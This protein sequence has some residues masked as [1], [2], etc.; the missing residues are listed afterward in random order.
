MF[1][2]TQKTWLT[3][4][5][6]IS[7]GLII[8]LDSLTARGTA[9]YI[10]YFIPVALCVFHKK[11][12]YPLW[13]ALLCSLLS[14]LGYVLSPVNALVANSQLPLLNRSFTIITLWAV[15]VLVRTIIIT[16]NQVERN[17]WLRDSAQKLAEIIRGELTTREVSEGILT[18]LAD[19]FHGKVGSLYLKAEKDNVLN[20]I[21]GHAYTP[22]HARRVM[23]LDDSLLGQTAKARKIRLISKLP[24]DYI[25]I[26]SSLGEGTPKNL[27]IVPFVADR[28]LIG[29]LELG[30]FDDPES[31]MEDFLNLISESC[32]IAIRSAEN[33]SRLAELLH[34]SQQQAEELQAQQEELRVVNEELEQQSRA[35]KDSHVRLENQQAELE[36]SNQ[37]L[38]EQAQALESQKDALD[39]KN[40]DL[41]MA[42]AALEQKAHELEKSSSYKS[43]FLANMSHELR[44]PLNSTLIL[45]KL[46]FDNKSGNLTA[47]Q[48]KYADIIYNSGNDLL[49]LINDIL[50]LS[51]VEAGKML[52]TPEVIDL[53]QIVTAME[54]NFSALANQ[55]KLQF[56]V[57]L[58]AGLPKEFISDKLRVEQILKNFLSNAFKFTSKGAVTLEISSFNQSIAFK[59]IDTGPGIPRSQQDVIFEA[60]RQADGTTN[61]KFGGT[62][63]GLSI[64]KELSRL[65]NG[66]ITIESQE[67]KGSIIT[68]ILPE[69]FELLS[70]ERETVEVK[71]PNSHIVAPAKNVPSEKP[72]MK[73][74][75][76]DDRETIQN[77]KRK[78]LIIEDDEPF[79]QILFG[80]AHENNFGALVAPTA[81][82]GL[83]LAKG[84]SPHAVL[85]DIRLPD[86]SGLMVLD[87]LKMDTKTRH[88]PVHIISSEDFTK[89]AMEM[90]AIGYMLKPV[91]HEQLLEA[92][93]NLT[94]IME[95]KIKR[96]LVV[97]DDEVQRNHIVSLIADPL[98]EVDAIATSREALQK[99]SERTYDCMIMDLSLP[100][101]SG[102]DLLSKLSK[103]NSTYSYPP[104]IVYTARDL[105]REEE[106]KLRLY[107]GS[108]IIKGAKSPERLLS[109]VTLF[110]HRV[111]TDMPAERQKMLKDL[112]SREK[113]LQ[114]R[115]LLVVDDDVRNIFALTSALEAFGARVEVARNGAEALE[116]LGN[117]SDVDLVLMDIMMPEMDGYEAMRRIRLEKRWKDLPII[118]LTAKAMK[119]DR[120]KC[121]EAGANDYLSKPLN[122]EKLLSLTRVWLPV[123]RRF[124]L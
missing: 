59:V 29:A 88:I 70:A 11:P 71:I 64:S 38:E 108:I 6:L 101:L 100:D 106:E 53:K 115:K 93:K 66:S 94:Q 111:E 46:L 68:L 34:Q 65:L 119:D 73:F 91:K 117:Q 41:Q 83:N 35:L 49:N 124:S 122:I 76:E 74:S 42:Q 37:Q 78:I 47:E 39:E 110:L 85:L 23:P 32:A 5:I 97:E 30:D 63:L 9:D 103:E 31:K 19:L 121:L 1:R 80:L 120:D 77:F 87:Q 69:K 114:N 58:S 43:E 84:L 24:T 26:S 67:G 90:G 28:E 109:E 56:K 123:K 113:T 13:I 4:I 48:I 40:Q 20:F 21:A 96:V 27:V 7:A 89:S 10:F 82:E 18:F 50:D 14:L 61:R 52:V 33:K 12:N 36:Q 104:V 102:H 62:G 22:D 45:A 17:N 8:V 54:N 16:K 3:P 75:F 86:H 15:A 95:Q 81:E 79:A 118:A 107:S 92:F 72:L 116:K 51:K 99:L 105:T 25:K 2:E 57:T 98:V 44:T 112:R 60:F 55:K